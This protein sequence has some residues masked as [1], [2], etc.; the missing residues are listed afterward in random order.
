MRVAENIDRQT[1]RKCSGV[2]RV[3]K[4]VS[5]LPI[6]YIMFQFVPVRTP[7]GEL[8]SFKYFKRLNNM[9][10]ESTSFLRL[11]RSINNRY[12]ETNLS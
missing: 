7:S 12:H 1:L 6:E 8:I 10:E 9:N 4:F 3:T 11:R 5:M 2:I